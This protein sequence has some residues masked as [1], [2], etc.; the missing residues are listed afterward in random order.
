M[1]PGQ[2]FDLLQLLGKH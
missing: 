2:H 1:N